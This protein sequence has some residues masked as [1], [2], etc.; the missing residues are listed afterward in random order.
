MCISRQ[1]S[2]TGLDKSLMLMMIKE[3]WFHEQVTMCY[4]LN[5]MK[6]SSQEAT[7]T[8]RPHHSQYQLSQ[9]EKALHS[10]A[11]SHWLSPY[12]ECSLLSRQREDQGRIQ[13]AQRGH[14]SEGADWLQITQEKKESENNSRISCQKRKFIF[15]IYIFIFEK[16]DKQLRKGNLVI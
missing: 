10:N 5:P 16:L 6:G 1:L 2:S 11:S 13:L 15:F 7:G 4:H 9:W 3:A 12:P 8:I 14:S